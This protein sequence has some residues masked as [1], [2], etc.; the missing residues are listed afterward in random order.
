VELLGEAFIMNRPRGWAH[1]FFEKSGGKLE[2]IAHRGGAGQW[3]G[4]TIYAIEQAIRIGVDIVE[5]DVHSTKN[6]ELVLIH[7]KTVDDTTN[8]T[9]SVNSFTLAELKELDAGYRWTADGG[10]TFPF[11]RDNSKG[12][13]IRV[14]TLEEVFSKFPDR[15]MNIEIKQTTPSIIKPFADMIRKH[16]MTNKVLVASMHH[17]ALREFRAVCP[18]V[19][20]SASPTELVKFVTGN[21]LFPGRDTIPEVDVPQLGIRFFKVPLP[22]INQRTVGAAHTLGLPIHAWTVNSLKDMWRMVSVGVDGIL[23]DYPGCLLELLKRIESGQ[24]ITDEIIRD[25]CEKLAP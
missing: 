2:V 20:T 1:P 22:F 25:G 6:G 11:R 4:E 15:R 16:E 7:N 17:S 14:P 18:E 10:K 3:P 8:G 13:D 9:G 21:T 5:I 23:T 19:A 12:I 24:E